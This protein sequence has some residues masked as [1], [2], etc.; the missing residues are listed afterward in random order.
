MSKIKS[1]KK[2]PDIGIPKDHLLEIDKFESFSDL[3]YCE[4]F[5]PRFLS[6][7]PINKNKISLEK[8]YLKIAGLC[9]NIKRCK[10]ALIRLSKCTKKEIEDSTLDIRNTAEN[11][12]QW[13][14]GIPVF[15]KDL[16]SEDEKTIY[17]P[18]DFRKCIRKAIIISEDFNYKI[19]PKWI[20]KWEKYSFSEENTSDDEI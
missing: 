7:I 10:N 8:Y 14:Q 6:S 12:K 3:Q 19:Y 16:L 15:F 17:L 5:L 20:E 4:F 18:E 1:K 9:K 13:V 11:V 2:L